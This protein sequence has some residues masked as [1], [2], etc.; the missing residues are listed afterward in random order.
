MFPLEDCVLGRSGGPLRLQGR[1]A[2]QAAA[3]RLASQARRRLRVLSHDL[4]PAVYD[5]LPFLEAVKALALRAPRTQVQVLLRDPGHAVRHGH[6]LVELARRLSSHVHLHRI[7]AEQWDGTEVQLI[8]DEQG[9]LRRPHFAAY[10]G[11]LH[12]HDPG[13][14]RQMAKAFDELW[15]HSGPEPEFRRLHL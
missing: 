13:G 2:V 15:E 9:Y 6:R 3:A 4:E 10:E 8:A 11:T 12:C 14:A 7:D 1:E 5:Q